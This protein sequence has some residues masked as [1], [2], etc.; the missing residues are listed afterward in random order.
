MK[1]TEA[2]MEEQLALLR[3]QYAQWFRGVVRD[4]LKREDDIRTEAALDRFA[5]MIPDNLPDTVRATLLY[6]ALRSYITY[7][8]DEN[9]A[10]YT[11]PAAL[12][13]GRAVCMGIADL[14][15]ILCQRLA[16]DCRVIVGYAGGQKPGGGGLHA[17]DLVRVTADDGTP[18]WYH[19]D[20]TWDLGTGARRYFLK[21][22][23]YMRLHDH[24]WRQSEY[25]LC[26]RS[27]ERVPVIPEKAVH[28][29]CQAIRKACADSY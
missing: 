9:A 21:S 22:D 7:D 2:Y 10:R 3:P 13:K 12:F 17:W 27:A 8:H 11:Y 16:L 14:Y 19:I 23:A 26:P 18:H 28:L 29:T 20:P 6:D 15:S 25:P 1:A 4:C 24:Y 5:A